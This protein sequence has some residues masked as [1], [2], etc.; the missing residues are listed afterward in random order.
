M[1]SLIR[2]HYDPFA[3]FDHLFEDAFNARFR[4]PISTAEVARSPGVRRLESFRPR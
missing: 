4:P 2:F 1:T 3:E